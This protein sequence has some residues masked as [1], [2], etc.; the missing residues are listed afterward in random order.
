MWP[1]LPSSS[2]RVAWNAALILPPGGG[3]FHEGAALPRRRSLLPSWDAHFEV[4]C[5]LP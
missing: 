5:W 2:G 1:A 4:D 3:P